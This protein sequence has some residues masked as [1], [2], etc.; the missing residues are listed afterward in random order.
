MAKMMFKMNYRNMT[1]QCFL[2][3]M[4]KPCLTRKCI[5]CGV[6][7]Y[8]NFQIVVESLQHGFYKSNHTTNSSEQVLLL[9][10]LGRDFPKRK[11]KAMTVK[12]RQK[13]QTEGIG[14]DFN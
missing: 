7:L 3:S 14:G 6:I 11:A 9:A 12:H 8:A 4:A 13:R 10:K 2:E 1:E 5:V